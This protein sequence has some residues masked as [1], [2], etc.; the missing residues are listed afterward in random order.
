MAQILGNIIKKA[1]G[2][3]GA[4]ELFIRSVKNTAYKKINI[5][6][7]S[8]NIK[9]GTAPFSSMGSA[10]FVANESGSNYI[11][12]YQVGISSGS[13]WTYRIGRFDYA[14]S[15]TYSQ[16]VIDGYG[17]LYYQ[18]N[19]YAFGNNWG[20]KKEG[21]PSS[22]NSW[23]TITVPTNVLNS[24]T[25]YVIYNNQVHAL[26]AGSDYLK[27]YKYDG[28]TWS[29]DISLPYSGSGASFCTANNKIYMLGGYNNKTGFYSYDGESWQ[30]ES[31]LPYEA[32]NLKSVYYK[33]YINIL[34]GKKYS[35]GSSTD[36]YEHYIYDFKTKEWIKLYNT[37]IIPTIV[38]VLNNSLYIANGS[39][40][41]YATIVYD[42]I[43]YT[44]R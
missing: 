8:T 27:H 20:R 37:Q 1:G 22:S 24:T 25:K 3:A 19:T 44:K 4:V 40:G 39:T 34:G 23:N 21:L 43:T 33:T 38:A 9:L 13:S 14:S 17:F 7:S 12:S 36:S 29:T 5:S 41:K 10:W 35:G 32:V 6:T 28:S 15:T 2:A 42:Y 18:G 30:E 26:G 11:Y 31:V 16:P